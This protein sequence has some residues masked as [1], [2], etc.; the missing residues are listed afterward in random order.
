MRL[1]LGMA[2]L[3]FA[4]LAS[5]AGD[6]P[7]FLYWKSTDLKMQSKT[8]KPKMNEMKVATQQLGGHGNYSFLLAHREGS[9]EAKGSTAVPL[10]PGG[11]RRASRSSQSQSGLSPTTARAWRR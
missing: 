1:K 2:V 6:P 9:G 4:G 7:G 10:Q 3:I 11:Q 5:P 8:L